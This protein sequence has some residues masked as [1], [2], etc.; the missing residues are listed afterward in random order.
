MIILGYICL[1]LQKKQN[2]KKK[3]K[4]NKQTKE[5]VVSTH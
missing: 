4:K 3:K 5:R 2:K 1:V